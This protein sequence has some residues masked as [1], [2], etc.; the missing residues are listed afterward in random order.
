MRGKA[1]LQ[2][3]TE[4][5]KEIR[6]EIEKLDE[7]RAMATN[8]TSCTDKEPVQSS[9]SQDKMA[10]LV[11]KIV[12]L[13]RTINLF[14][15]NLADNRETAKKIIFKIPNEDYQNILYDRYIRCMRLYEIAEEY[16]INYELC[17]KRHNR[18]LKAFE[19]YYKSDEM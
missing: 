19:K 18:A 4:G 11:A 9:S 5:N 13:E 1:F 10:G 12:D 17:K 16:E 6:K 3:L 7:L 8:I 2:S 15:D 14:T